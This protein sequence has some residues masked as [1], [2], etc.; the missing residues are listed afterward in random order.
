[1]RGGSDLA[2]LL[3]EYDV[4]V[5]CVAVGEMTESRQ[6]CGI[7]DG[8]SP[9]ALV[10]RNVL[11]HIGLELRGNAELVFAHN[12]FEIVQAPFEVVA[13]C[14]G[15]LQTVGRANVEHEEPVDV[16]DQRVLIEIGREQLRVAGFY[17]P[18]AADIQV[19]ALLGCNH[20]DV[21]A[22][23]LSAFTG[24]S[25]HA[26]LDL[27]GRAATS[28]TVLNFNREADAVLHAEAA[29]CRADAGLH[30]A[31]GL[32]VGM[33]RLEAG[34]DQVGPDERQLMHLRTKQVDTLAAGDL[35]VEAELARDLAQDDQLF[36]R[37]LA[38]WNARYYGVCAVLLHVGE[39]VVIGVLERCMLAGEHELVPAGGQN[40]GHGR[41]ADVAT[42]SA[43]VFCEGCIE[44]AQAA[45][46]DKRKQLLA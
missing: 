9:F 29:P 39:K 10:A 8:L 40:G 18:V 43:P 13:P 45:Y 35:G 32:T 44:A 46:P 11:R 20:S 37:D 26:E 14:R 4:G 41:H 36:R 31:H 25:R 30:C 5:R 23:R 3:H 12:L 34:G 19:P 22:L 24:A 7:L 2:T 28:V 42:Q 1:M 16:A 33:P 17:S 6:R 15:A 38:A 21:L 27:V